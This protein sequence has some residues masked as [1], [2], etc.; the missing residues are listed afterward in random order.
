V[1]PGGAVL[2]AFGLVACDVERPWPALEP[3]LERM[4]VQPHAEPY[5]AADA[6]A[7][8]SAMRHP[9]RGT[10]PYVDPASDRTATA[11]R[12][13]DVALLRRGQAAFETVCAA[14]HGILGDGDTPVAER[15]TLRRPPSLH[16]P[17]IRAFTPDRNYAVITEG[18]GLMP[19]Y[20]AELPEAERW[21][22]TR[23]LRALQLSYA[24]DLDSL[25]SATRA[26][27]DRDLR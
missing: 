19:A 11:P 27:A 24:V 7:N 5:E 9:P 6:F 12:V 20:A 17:R 22:V 1:S 15:M 21:A 23:Y 8:H 4:M 10:E 16:E 25:D 2:V 3:S 18:Y 26:E 13:V 14:C